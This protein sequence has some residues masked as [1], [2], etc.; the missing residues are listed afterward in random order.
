[1]SRKQRSASLN[2]FREDPSITVILVSIGAGG[3]GL[4]LTSANKVFMME[5]QFNPQAEAQAVDR[6]HRLGQE[7]EV[8]IQRFIMRGSFEERML[9][10]QQ[11]KKDLAD[12]S[13]NRKM[14]KKELAEQKMK[15]LRELFK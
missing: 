4:N 8:T 15:E 7:R 10:L 9:V 12:M 14:D 6:V 3:L 2:S 1:M 11:K 13:L 5:P